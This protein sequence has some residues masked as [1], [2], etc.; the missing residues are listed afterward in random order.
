[1]LKLYHGLE[2][3]GYIKNAAPDG[4]W[5]AG[6]VELTPAAEAYRDAFAFMTDDEKR[7]S[8]PPFDEAIFD[9]WFVE[10]ESGIRK[11][12][13]FPAVHEDGEIYWRC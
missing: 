8:K 4:L 9:N 3:I 1:M 7:S 13:I 2:L 5:M 12:T 11:E 10:D 6:E